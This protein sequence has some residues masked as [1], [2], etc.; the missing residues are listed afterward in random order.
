MS[1]VR[2]SQPPSLGSNSQVSNSHLSDPLG[3]PQGPDPCDG[4]T[5]PCDREQEHEPMGD[6]E[7]EPE[8]HTR[9]GNLSPNSRWSNQSPSSRWRSST[10]AKDRMK[11]LA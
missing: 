10:P 9:W 7:S 8:S 4:M 2:D 11:S 3:A 6:A 1:R 5:L